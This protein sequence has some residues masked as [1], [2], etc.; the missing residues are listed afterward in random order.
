MNPENNKI[1]ASNNINLRQIA[2]EESPIKRAKTN[3]SVQKPDKAEQHKI[4]T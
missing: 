2:N 1:V 4:L 3:Q